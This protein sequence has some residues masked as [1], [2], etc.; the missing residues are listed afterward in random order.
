[1]GQALVIFVFV[2][3]L[4]MF[5][6]ALMLSQSVLPGLKQYS[7]WITLVI[8]IEFLETA[9]MAS[10][11]ASIVVCQKML[12]SKGVSYLGPAFYKLI[13]AWLLP[14]VVLLIRLVFGVKNK[15][16]HLSPFGLL[17][18][19]LEYLPD[20]KSEMEASHFFSG[21]TLFTNTASLYIFVFPVALL[22]AAGHRIWTYC[23]STKSESAASPTGELQ[24]LAPAD[25]KRE[26]LGE[27]E[28]Q[29]PDIAR[30][31]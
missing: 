5:L 30:M 31:V 18:W 25:E 16:H 3:P 11:V 4:S 8:L 28:G 10:L 21:R 17:T 14:S 29:T 7:S 20:L 22:L 9:G 15:T 23:R 26:K 19:V 6:S 2:G 1:M 12:P 27:M 13:F 24:E